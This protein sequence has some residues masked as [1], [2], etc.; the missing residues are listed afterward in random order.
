[1]PTEE[2]R[3]FLSKISEEIIDL[4][5]HKHKLEHTQVA[6]LLV[7]LQKTHADALKQ[8]G[9]KYSIDEFKREKL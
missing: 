3:G 9:V 7:N 1:M 4:L 2:E 8:C 5:Q 6:W